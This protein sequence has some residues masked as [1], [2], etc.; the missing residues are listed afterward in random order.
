MPVDSIRPSHAHPLTP[1]E[2]PSTHGTDAARPRHALG[3]PLSPGARH[4]LARH[5]ARAGRVAPATPSPARIAE[6]LNEFLR[7]MQGPY[8]VG[9]KQVEVPA[10]FRMKGGLNQLSRQTC[11]ARI[12]KAL[13]AKQYAKLARDTA[14]VTEGKASPEEIRRVTQALIDSPAFAKYAALPPER[15]VRHLM[16]DY[17][18]GTDCSGYV[19]N[20][21]LYSRGTAMGRAAPAARYALGTADNSGLQHLPG[22]AFRRV[23]P[24]HARPGDVMVLTHGPDG[25]GHK[26]IVYS[27]RTILPSSPEYAACAQALGS[28]AGA[29]IDLLEVDSSWGAGGNPDDGGVGR[30]VWAYGENTHRWASVYKDGS[31]LHAV[32]S[33][34]TG[35]YDHELQGIYRPRW[36]K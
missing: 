2:A 9:G 5:A 26:L 19:H 8:T 6:R 20:A 28:P 22:R 21:F 29:R 35:P 16:W 32:R 24:E 15:A 30:R 34:K 10:G 12:A 23:E 14:M 18:I 1:A 4:V 31:G 7:A 33:S 36:E 11:E 13:G 17:G 27:H 25:T 3:P